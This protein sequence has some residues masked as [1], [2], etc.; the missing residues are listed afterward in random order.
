MKKRTIVRFKTKQK[1]C[2]KFMTDLKV[3]GKDAQ[4]IDHRVVRH[5]DEAVAISIREADKLAENAKQGVEW[6]DQHRHLLQE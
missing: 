2:N 4:H 6:L 5:D 1:F 3:R